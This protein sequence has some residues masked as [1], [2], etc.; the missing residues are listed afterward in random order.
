M[1]K[2][3]HIGIVGCSPPG[4]A[5]CYQT[6]CMEGANSASGGLSSPQVSMHSYPLSEYMRRIEAGDWEDVAD[7]MLSSAEKLA[8]IG[9][10]ILIAPCN[11]IHRAFELVE[12]RSPLP[13][14]HIAKEVATEAKRLGYRKVALLGTR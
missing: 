12:P 11:T 13:W 6:I 3:Q 2:T 8:S 1:S 10:Q 5:L 7:L 4:A 14:L 9:A